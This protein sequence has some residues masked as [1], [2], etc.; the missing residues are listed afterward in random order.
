MSRSTADSTYDPAEYDRFTEWLRD[1]SDWEEATR[2]RFV[3]AYRTGDLS[4]D[5]FEQYLVQDYQFLET[6]A[7]VT[8]LAVNQAHTMEE[9]GQLTESLAVLTG[10]ENDYFQRAFDALSVPG[11]DRERPEIHPTTAAF[12]DFMLRAAN[13][14]TY[15]ETLAAIAPAEWVYLDWCEHAEADHERW[16]LDEW[17]EIHVNEEFEAYVDWLRTQ[18]DTYGP[19]LSPERQR[20]VAE[21]FDR[22]VALE[23]AFF[24]AAYS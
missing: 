22:T 7:R 15:E 3:E 24:D 16:Y 11:A 21:I 4:D 17:V 1:R 12:N 8:A 2:H 5:V 23:A 10:G 14:G 13:E 19:Q 18:L 6:G 9:M 20:R